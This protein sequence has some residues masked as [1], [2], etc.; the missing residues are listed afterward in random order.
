MSVQLTLVAL[1]I[2]T[3]VAVDYGYARNSATLTRREA[4]DATRVSDQTFPYD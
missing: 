4:S 3:Y 1:G 2:V